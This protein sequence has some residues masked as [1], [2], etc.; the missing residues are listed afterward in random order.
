MTQ[1]LINKALFTVA[2][3]EQVTVSLQSV[4]CNCFTSAGFDGQALTKQSSAPDAYTFTVAG[5][6]GDQKLFAGV[7]L[8]PTGTDAFA[9]YTVQVSND[10]GDQF[11]AS[12]VI[13]VIPRVD[14]QLTFAIE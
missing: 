9:R 2:S 3:C 7:C 1:D 4:G 8:F 5:N 11:Q 14:F 6:R 10:K 13:C 12:P